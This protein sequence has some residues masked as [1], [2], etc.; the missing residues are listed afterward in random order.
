VAPVGRMKPVIVPLNVLPVSTIAAPA[1][2]NAI[3]VNVPLNSPATARMPSTITALTSR[4]GARLVQKI[5]RPNVL[6]FL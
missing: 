6:M 4:V 1:T 2:R 5:N 3:K